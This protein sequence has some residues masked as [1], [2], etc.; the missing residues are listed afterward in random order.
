MTFQT[1]VVDQSGTP[2]GGAFV[3]ANVE[4]TGA[5]FSRFTDGNGYADVAMLAGAPEGAPVTFTVSADGFA[6]ASQYLTIGADNQVIKVT[7]TPFV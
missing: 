4:T 2:V 3:L 7:L 5:S 6:R 1:T